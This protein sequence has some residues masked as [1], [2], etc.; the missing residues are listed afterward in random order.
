MNACSS[1]VRLVCTGLVCLILLAAASMWVRPA[2]AQQLADRPQPFTDCP[3]C[4]RMVRVPGGEFMMGSP[5]DEKFREADEGPQHR[6]R[7]A[8]LAVALTK[9][10]RGEYAAFVNATQ[11]PDSDGCWVWDTTRGVWAKDASK[12]WRNPGFE[13]TDTHPV[14]CVSWD[15]ARAYSEWLSGKTNKSY[16]LLTESEREYVTRAGSAA[17]RPWGDK[18]EAACR[19]ANVADQTAG[20]KVQR[21]AAWIECSDGYAYTSP[22]A[23]FQPNAFGLF[24]TIGNAWEWVEDCYHDS[25]LGAPAD[26][27]AWIA[28]SCT[29]R[30]FRGGSWDNYPR[31]VRSAF[32]Y[33]AAPGTRSSS[34]GFR[35]AR[36]L[37]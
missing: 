11:R 20:A 6:V 8:S 16:R 28:P 32:R 33:R 35:I 5:P 23:S 18:V 1:K 14:V 4:P 7:I 31:N 29:D 3:D 36:S 15:D 12:S 30:V 17:A 25:Y 34:V 37:P 26:G 13:Q 24:D 19:Y 22:V 27:S 2:H 9:V 21:I 10:T